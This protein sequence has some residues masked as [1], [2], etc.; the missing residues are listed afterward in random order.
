MQNRVG[1]DNISYQF[2]VYGVHPDATYDISIDLLYEEDADDSTH[3]P[4]T[5]MARLAAITVKLPVIIFP[6]EVRL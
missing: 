4:T 5:V 6:R 3:R 1:N 2:P